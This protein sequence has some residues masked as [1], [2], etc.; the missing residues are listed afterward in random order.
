[1]GFGISIREQTSCA[2]GLGSGGTV[3]VVV[4]RL[5]LCMKRM[6]GSKEV[7]EALFRILYYC[8]IALSMEKFVEGV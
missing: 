4:R 6:D 2:D 5:D 3:G 7:E 8:E 1:M